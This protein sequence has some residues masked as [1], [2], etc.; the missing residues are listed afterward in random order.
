M[1][2][3]K[4]FASI[5][6]AAG[7]REIEVDAA[8]I[9]ELLRAAEERY[10]EVFAER[11]A[12]CRVVVNGEAVTDPSTPVGDGDEVAILP[13]VSGG[14]GGPCGGEGSRRAQQRRR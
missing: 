1:P 4:L 11:L 8:T 6:E 9:G 10:G 3:A 14:A 5:A 7:A 12:H 2:K 13:P